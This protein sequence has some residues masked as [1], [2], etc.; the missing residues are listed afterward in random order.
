VD[1]ADNG[2]DGVALAVVTSLAAGLWTLALA[3]FLWRWAGTPDIPLQ[4][5]PQVT[6]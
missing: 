5:Q 1:L 3:V 6:Q 4:P 2:F